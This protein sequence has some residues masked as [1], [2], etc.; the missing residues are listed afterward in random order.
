[1]SDSVDRGRRRFFGFCAASA[2]MAT[3]AAPRLAALSDAEPVSAYARAHLVLP[4]GRPL[5]AA[6]LESGKNYIFHYPY[7]S[8]P[9]FL[10]DLGR[11]IT[12]SVELRTRED[13]EYV[14]NGGV[15]PNRSIVAFSA[16]CAHK[17]THP[18][19]QASFISYHGPGHH[20]P[21]SKGVIHCCSENSVYDPAAGA[22][23]LS[24]PA[25]EPLAAIELEYDADKDSLTA[26][27][28]T[29]GTLFDRFLEKFR[30]RLMIAHGEE[31]YR[32]RIK[33]RTEVVSL[34]ELTKSRF[35]C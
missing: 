20:E 6:T 24:G 29:G 9:C 32:R 34:D 3:A 5:K 1:M 26:V 4:D 23:V 8:T 12:R 25:P 18:A 15:G 33:D 17:M 22:Q 19:R 31:G 28:A 11:P 27:G 21:E 16:I 14:W 7:A 35:D 10:L 30:D 13:H 2:A